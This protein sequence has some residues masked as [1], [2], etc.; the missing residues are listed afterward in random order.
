MVR[1][2]ARSNRG[3]L[4]IQL[5]SCFSY[6]AVPLIKTVSTLCHWAKA[7]FSHGK[8]AGSFSGA[9]AR[10]PAASPLPCS[11]SPQRRVLGDGSARPLLALIYQGCLP[12]VPGTVGSLQAALQPQRASGTA[13]SCPSARCFGTAGSQPAFGTS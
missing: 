10:A 7:S 9:G 8:E 13:R 5:R 4:E 1:Q 6:S 3:E 12:R 11:L 2:R